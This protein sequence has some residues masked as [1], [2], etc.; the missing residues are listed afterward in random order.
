MKKIDVGIV[1]VLIGLI[2]FFG[3]I[4]MNSSVLFLIGFF[5]FCMSVDVDLEDGIYLK[6][7]I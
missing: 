7:G 3:G 6:D 4:L 5:W 2:L 1:L